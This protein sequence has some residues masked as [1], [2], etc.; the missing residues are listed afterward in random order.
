MT[1][2]QRPISTRVAADRL[3]CSVRT[4]RRMIAAG[5]LPAIRL[6]RQLRVPVAALDALWERP[7]TFTRQIEGEQ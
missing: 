7:R 2:S 3:G 4:I 1:D 6:R 5:R